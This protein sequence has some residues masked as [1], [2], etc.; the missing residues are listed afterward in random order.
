M[1]HGVPAS[2][3]VCPPLQLARQSSGQLSF[4]SRGDGETIVFLHGLLGSSKS[5]AFQF[6]RL[7]QNY[8]VVAWD[9]P[10]FGQSEMVPA[11]I[12][13]YAETLRE[14]V[15]NVGRPNVSLVGHS[16]GG[17]VAARLAAT[18]PELVSRLVLS[19]SHAGYGDPETAPMSA[20]F[21]SRKREFD[22][23]GHAAYGVNRA[24]DLLPESVPACV[25]DHAAEIASEINPEGLR[26]ATRMLQC[27]DNRPLLPKLKM[28][29]L[30]LTGEMDTDV[31]PILK[32]DLLKLAPA[33]MT[34]HVEM[35]G[36]GHAPYFEAPDY[37]NSLI[38]DFLSEK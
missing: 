33:P 34:K 28:P 18:F 19:C 31:Q 12:D 30:V 38:E 26:R 4:R 6:E 24:R 9:A 3:P 29:I 16:M 8:R 2:V 20:K 35:P 14:F 7:S 25:F 10:G 23:I 17:A 27:A 15:A 36:L 5:W 22:E 1:I 37:F 32:A 11:S 13:A 21:E